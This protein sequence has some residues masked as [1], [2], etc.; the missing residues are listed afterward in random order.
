MASYI[1]HT[2]INAQSYGSYMILKLPESGLMDSAWKSCWEQNK[3]VTSQAQPCLLGPKPM[4]L[5]PSGTACCDLSLLVSRDCFS[6]G[7]D[8]KW[9]AGQQFFFYKVNLFFQKIM[10]IMYRQ[11]HPKKAPHTQHYTQNLSKIR[12]PSFIQ[13]ITNLSRKAHLLVTTDTQAIQT[14]TASGRNSFIICVIM[15]CALIN[16]VG[17]AVLPFCFFINK[18]IF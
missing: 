3:N 14:N 6:G 4:C 17:L 8:S 13:C 5:K 10:Y 1:D 11:T 9:K 12:H 2:Q 16:K 15:G 18:K 7:L